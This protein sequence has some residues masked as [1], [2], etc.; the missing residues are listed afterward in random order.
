MEEEEEEEK[1]EDV[2]GKIS[3]AFI[4]VQSGNDLCSASF[5]DRDDDKD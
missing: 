2:G 5:K 3:D 4:L 1:E